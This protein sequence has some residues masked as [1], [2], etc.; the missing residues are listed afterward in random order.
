MF[1]TSLYADHIPVMPEECIRLMEPKSGG[2]YADGTLGAGGHSEAILKASAPDGTLLSFDLDPEAI[3][4]AG[5]RLAPFG[6][7]VRIIHD[8]YVNLGRYAE[9]NSLDGFIVD[10]GV[11][12]MQLDHR[13]RGFS[14]LQ[15]GPLDMRFSPDQP[16][17]AADIVNTWPEEELSRILWQYGEERKSRQIAAM[18]CAERERGRIETTAQLRDVI[19]SAVGKGKEKIHPATRS[20]QAIRI[21]VNGELDAVE[22]VLPA[23]VKALKPGGRL[24]VISFHSLEDRIVKNYFKTESKDCLCPPEQPVCTCGHKAVLKELTRHPVTA[25]DA[26]IEKNPRSRSAKLRAAV[27]L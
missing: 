2:H 5:E 18:I 27:K 16:L 26:E 19:L 23:A 11:S 6:E 24:L 9:E 4:I 7:R 21:A 3:R 20:F 13:D 10:L 25:G 1:D 15:D 22:A 12:S 8:S 17:T 14:F